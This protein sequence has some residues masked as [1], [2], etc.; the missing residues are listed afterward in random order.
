MLIKIK[1]WFT[2]Y[3][4]NHILKN[5]FLKDLIMMQFLEHVILNI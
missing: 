4:F 5:T 2:N 1:N 3:D